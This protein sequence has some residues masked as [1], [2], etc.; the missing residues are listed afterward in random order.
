[1]FRMLLHDNLSSICD[2][3]SQATFHT[4]FSKH[5]LSMHNQL[6]LYFFHK[7]MELNVF[8]YKG[9]IIHNGSFFSTYV[10][11]ILMFFNIF[12]RIGILLFLHYIWPFFRF[13]HNCILQFNL[14]DHKFG[15]FHYGKFEDINEGKK[16]L[17]FFGK[18]YHMNEVR[19][20]F[21]VKD[22]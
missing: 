12:F 10:F 8:S 9:N 3:H 15:I 18:A 5:K 20:L 13:S 16:V 14:H 19:G 2:S 11:H 21:I 1:M 17:S 6:H 4:H 22:L 7:N